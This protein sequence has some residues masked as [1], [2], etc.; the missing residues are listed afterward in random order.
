MWSL[1]ILAPV[2][3][4]LIGEVILYTPI[5]FNP[6]IPLIGIWIL[7]IFLGTKHILGTVTQE[8]MSVGKFTI[9]YAIFTVLFTFA[10]TFIGKSILTRLMFG[11]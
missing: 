5:P 4:I 3:Y 10:V 11:F 8:N 9:L 2:V 1:I 7:S 6:T